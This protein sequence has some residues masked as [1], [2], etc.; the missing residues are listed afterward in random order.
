M[1]DIPLVRQ[2]AEGAEFT[3]CSVAPIAA[4]HTLNESS[5]LGSSADRKGMALIFQWWK[6]HLE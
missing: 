2:A 5:M 1:S 4:L 3:S 6:C